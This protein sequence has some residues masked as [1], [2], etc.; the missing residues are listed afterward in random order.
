MAT[1]NY[2]FKEISCTIVDYGCGLCGKTTNLIHVHK[3]VPGK[4]R[5]ELVSL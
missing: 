5:G 1:L 4:F 2:A 3:T